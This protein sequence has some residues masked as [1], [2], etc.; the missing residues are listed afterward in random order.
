MVA[1]NERLKIIG[2]VFNSSKNC[3]H[4]V[5]LHYKWTDYIVLHISL[6]QELSSNSI[7][8]RKHCIADSFVLHCTADSFL[9]R[10]S[11]QIFLYLF[12]YI[13]ND[14]TLSNRYTF[15]IFKQAYFALQQFLYNVECYRIRLLSINELDSLLRKT[16]YRKIQKLCVT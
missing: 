11:N 12:I 6:L 13:I 14:Q 8:F 1:I 2:Y 10:S 5:S 9:K 3:I 4:Y 15:A 16:L 7:H